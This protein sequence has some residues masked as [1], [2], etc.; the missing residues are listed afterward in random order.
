MDAA[1]AARFYAVKYGDVVENQLNLKTKEM[2]RDR[3]AGRD[4]EMVGTLPH[5]YALTLERP[6]QARSP[7]ES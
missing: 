1:A 2:L 7:S 4:V 6:Q 3:V 5:P